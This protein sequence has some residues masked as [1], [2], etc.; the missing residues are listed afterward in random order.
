VVK[1]DGASD[2][3]GWRKEIVDACCSSHAN[4][5]AVDGAGN[6]VAAGKLKGGPGQFAVIKFDG[7]SGTELW[8]QG[9]DS[10]PGDAKA[11]A[12]DGAGNVTAAGYTGYQGFGTDFTVIKFDGGSGTEWWRQIINGAGGANG[13]EDV[14]NAVAV[15][16]AGNV[17]VAGKIMTANAPGTHPAWVV[18]SFDGA[19]GVE[20]WRKVDGDIDDVTNNA[21]SVAVDGA[22]N[23]VAAG[24]L[25]STGTHYFAVTKYEGTSGTEL[26]QQRIHLGIAHAVVVD[27]AGDV[28]A[29][30]IVSSA[31]AVV[32]LRGTDGSD[33]VLDTEPPAVAMTA[34][35]NGAIVSGTITVSAEASDNVG[36]AGVQFQLDGA[37]L[38]AEDT[39]AP[40]AVTWDT[41]TTGIGQHSLTA[42]ARDAAGN[43]STAAPVTVT[44]VNLPALPALPGL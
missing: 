22:G 25:N 34:P 8:R 7:A 43:S 42:V 20:R 32:K 19:S 17:A 26:W 10:L 30:G 4:A 13:S 2:T 16:G 40:Y 27:G 37:P 36:V 12:V 21:N 9:S 3:Q 18:M 23:V 5:V 29:A 6:V 35:A 33:F 1:L 24:S 31:G 15:D 28:I 44:V 38:G 41:A 11:V 14:A 39:E